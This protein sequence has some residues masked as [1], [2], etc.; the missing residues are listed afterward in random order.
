[1]GKTAYIGPIYINENHK[2]KYTHAARGAVMLLLLLWRRRSYSSVSMVHCTQLWCFHVQVHTLKHIRMC[3]C[4]GT[5]RT[6]NQLLVACPENN[7]LATAADLPPPRLYNIILQP[8]AYNFSIIL[9]SRV[10]VARTRTATIAPLLPRTPTP[11]TP[12]SRYL[13][14]ALS[15]LHELVRLFSL[16][17]DDSNSTIYVSA[18][19]NMYL[20]IKQKLY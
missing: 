6:A 8:P 12:T 17:D 2:K 20:Y 7:A 1:M 9:Y 5:R 15:F 10:F 19:S 13:K 3:V 18:N 4:I 16:M 14:R 11:I